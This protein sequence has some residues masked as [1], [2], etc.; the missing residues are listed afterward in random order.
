MET[1]SH[2][3]VGQKLAFAGVLI[4]KVKN[5]MDLELTGLLNQIAEL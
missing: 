5:Y 2:Y 3:N 4:N 1:I